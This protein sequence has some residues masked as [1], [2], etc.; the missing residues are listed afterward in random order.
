VGLSTSQEKEDKKMGVWVLGREG[1]VA[2]LTLSRPPVNALD[3]ENLDELGW[4]ASRLEADQEVRVVVIIGGIEGI[5]CSGGDLKYWGK[6]RDG[7]EVS[8]AG[9]QVFSRIERLPQPTI[10]AINGQVI[11][12]GLTLALA[13]DFRIASEAATFRLPEVAYGF[14]PGWG[15]IHRLVALVGRARAAELL[16]TGQ[17]LE[18]LLAQEIGLINEAVP[19]DQLKA[20]AL[21][22]ALELAALSPAAL[23][24]AK[25][26]LSGGDER[27]CFMTV[28]G[29]AD[30]QEGIDAL[31]NKRLPRFDS[32]LKRQFRYSSLV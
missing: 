5:F 20:R 30:W 18:A 8:R 27:A 10:A 16:L 31:L 26:A 6:I 24:A 11:G 25:C 32:D 13:C 4:I 14:I 1:E 9:R 19:P 21:K 22:R 7:R 23:R 15:L 29:E 17:R 12:D 28:W 2:L 3:Q